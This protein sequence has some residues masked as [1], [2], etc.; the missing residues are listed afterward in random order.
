MG[1]NMKK[2]YIASVAS[3]L[4]N[5]VLTNKDLEK[6]VDTSDEWIVQRTGIK[7]RHLVEE[8]QDTTDVAY[9][10]AKLAIE[11]AGLSP[12]DIDGIIVATASGDLYFP[13]VATNVAGLLGNENCFGY[14]VNAACSGF[15]FALNSADNAI[16][17][18]QAKN[19]VVIGV[20]LLSKVID[21]EDRN[22]C[23]LFGDGSGAVVLSAC[24]ESEDF[25]ILSTHIYS[26]GGK[27][28]LLRSDELGKIGL[29]MDGQAVYKFAVKAMSDSIVDALKHNNLEKTDIDWVVPH[30]ANLR[31][32]ESVANN[33]GMD[34][35]KVIV[36][37][38]N[39]GN[40]SAATIPLAL[41]TAFNDG[42]F[43]TGD[44]IALT[45][46]GGGFAWGSAILKWK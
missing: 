39:H 20:D 26:S 31:I 1:N 38:E 14:D 5:K 12:N 16:R 43:K 25:G 15:I 37:L 44:M 33:L 41:D 42:K 40:T 30:Q 22:T 19:I 7:Q 11:R 45:A 36:S 46:M 8:G 23:V 3:Y 10:S 17:L 32:I 29:H 34:M 28:E 35:E 6:F 4:P 27:A 21:W 13:S 18:G 2:S 9:Q 24:E